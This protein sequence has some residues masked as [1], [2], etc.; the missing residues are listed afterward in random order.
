MKIILEDFLSELEKKNPNEPEFIQAVQSVS[1][2]IVPYINSQQDLLE[3][4]IL[5]RIVEPERSILFKITWIDDDGNVH[6]NKGYRVQMNS[7]LGPYKGGLRFHP[8]VNL[9]ILKFLA[10][11]QTFKNSLTGLSLGSGK[12]GADFDPRGRSE[13]EIM[14][15]CQA[16]IAELHRHIGAELDVP[17]GDIGVAEREVGFMFGKYKQ[18]SNEFTG[19]LT[20]KGQSWGGSKIRKE[21]TGYGVI[22]FLDLMLKERGDTLKGKRVCISGAG[23]VARGAAYKAIELG[24]KVLTLSNI[25]G[26]LY[27][28]EGFTKEMID[29][30]ENFKLSGK[31]DLKDFAK[32]YHAQYLESKKPWSI[33]N[34]IAIPCATQNEV[35]EQ[36]ANQ[37]IE[38]GCHYVIEGAN[39]PCDLDAVGLFNKHKISYA[40]GKAANAG[41]V[42]VSG[43]EMAQNK[44][45]YGWTA[46]E[47]DSK[48]KEIMD[49]IHSTCVQ[50]GKEDGYVNY[51]KGADIG[52]FVKVADAMK[53]QGVL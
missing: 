14:R 4:N 22:Y 16:F 37:L 15:F 2:H 41:G 35:N 44:L 29:Y 6:V 50:Y 38:H 48:L 12:G 23:N 17:A 28:P 46:E 53:A 7:A 31:T 18:L 5:E 33:P 30:V 1:E 34:D 51:E 21:A 11:E 49:T 25:N 42:A 40:P 3:L 39:M 45:G 52:G 10:F 32:K 13:R 27:D 43:L 8:S 24:A 26:T 19:V 36:D 20:G 47:V 9:S